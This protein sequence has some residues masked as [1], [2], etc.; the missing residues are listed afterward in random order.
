MKNYSNH[1]RTQLISDLKP[2]VFSQFIRSASKF[3]VIQRNPH[4][5]K[6]PE[7]LSSILSITAKNVEQISSTKLIYL[8]SQK[9]FPKSEV[10]GS[11]L[12]L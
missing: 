3:L 12:T 7:K 11:S 2:I 10:T 5:Y 4:D 8:F 6:T 9:C 1:R